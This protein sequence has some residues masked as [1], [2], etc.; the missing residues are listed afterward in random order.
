MEC[1]LTAFAFP[2]LALCWCWSLNPACSAAFINNSLLF[3]FLTFYALIFLQLVDVLDTGENEALSSTR[4]QLGVQD[5]WFS[6][7]VIGQPHLSEAVLI[8][9]YFCRDIQHMQQETWYIKFVPATPPS[10][11]LSLTFL[12]ECCIN[13]IFV[14]NGVGCTS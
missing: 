2:I 4:W 12:P 5:T 11:W 14:P 13:N 9:E 8:L 7:N 3:I 1:S 10:G 6:S